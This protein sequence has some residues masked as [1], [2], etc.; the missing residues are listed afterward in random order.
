M[1]KI[2]NLYESCKT[3]IRVAYVGFLLIA[4]GFLIQNESVNVFYTFR[5]NIILFLAELFLRIGELIIMNLPIIF[6]LNIVCKRANNASPVVM[7]LVGYF[8]FVVT[9]MLFANQ[10]M[11]SLAYSTGYGVNSV[12]NIPT[13]SRLPLETGMIGSIMVAYATR[14]AFILSRHRSSFSITNIFSKDTAGIVYNFIFCFILGIAVSYVYPFFFSYLQRGIRFISADLLDPLRIGAYSVVD[15][16]LSI[17]GLNNIIRYPFWYTSAGGSYSN[18]LTGQSVL[19]DVNIWA[20][21][22]NS[23][24]SYVGAGRFITPFYVINMFMIPAFY[25]GTLLSMSD[26]RQRNGFTIIF[27]AGILL[28]II[29]GNP[30]PSELLMLT[31]SPFLLVAYLIMVGLVSGTL[32]NFEAFLGFSSKISNT[33]IAMPGSFAD[34]IINIR[35]ASLASSIRIILIVG[36]IAFVAMFALTMFYYRFIAFDFTNSG[37]GKQTVNNIIAAAGGRDNIINAGSGLFSLNIDIRDPEK[38]SIEKIHE[39]GIRKVL[40]TRHGLSFE[41]G[42]SSYG[43]ARAINREINRK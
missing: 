2:M 26:I 10:S 37:T 17:V 34:F 15:R 43:A 27:I 18:S 16:L 24:A 39:I 35:N 33:T 11:N 32:V 22:K 12:F 14:I 41:L 9:T 5:S 42:T 21:L 36:L 20:Y 7:A 4:F 30:L 29:A 3:P 31:T 40:E 19:G 38:I 13:G 1:K 25:L 28:S 23:N 8:A 6:M